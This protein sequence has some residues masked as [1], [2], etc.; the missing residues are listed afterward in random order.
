LEGRLRLEWISSAEATKFVQVMTDFT[1]QIR[2][3]GPSPLRQLG[4]DWTAFSLPPVT[5][6]E[7]RAACTCGHRGADLP[8]TA[9]A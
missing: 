6:A 9:P 4:Q 5:E 1:E 2:R 8:P 7:A 3:L